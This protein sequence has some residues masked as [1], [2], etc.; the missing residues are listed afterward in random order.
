MKQEGQNKSLF[1]QICL[2][3]TKITAASTTIATT[4]T[5]KNTKIQYFIRPLESH[6]KLSRTFVNN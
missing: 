1:E 4:K 3:L 6:G 5:N 2:M